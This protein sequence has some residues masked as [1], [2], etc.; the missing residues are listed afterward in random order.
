MLVLDYCK[1]EPQFL[2]SVIFCVYLLL[3][4]GLR[5]LQLTVAQILYTMHVL[6]HIYTG[7][8]YCSIFCQHVLT[9]FNT[10]FGSCGYFNLPIVR[11]KRQLSSVHCVLLSLFLGSLFSPRSNC[12]STECRHSGLKCTPWCMAAS[13]YIVAFEGFSDQGFVL[14]AV[15]SLKVHSLWL[16]KKPLPS[17]EEPDI[18]LSTVNSKACFYTHALHTY[19]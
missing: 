4:A 8:V 6:F 3:H 17:R 12:G 1:S 5:L 19:Y 9:E 7:Y 2:L 14:P 11:S 16:L 13:Q 15:E 18:S 10:A